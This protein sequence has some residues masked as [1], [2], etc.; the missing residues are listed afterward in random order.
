MA[1]QLRQPSPPGSLHPHHGPPG[2]H[3]QLNGH[4]PQQPKP[5]ITPQH[6]SQLNEVVWLQIGKPSS[7]LVERK[8]LVSDEFHR[9]PD[10]A[11]GRPRR[12]NRCVRASFTSQ[13]VLDTC[14]E[15]YI[16][17]TEDEGK[18]SQSCRI[19]S[20]H[21]EVRGEQRRSLGQ[22]G[23]VVK[24]AD[25]LRNVLTLC[26]G[27]CYLMMEDLQQ[28]YSAYQQALYYLRDPKV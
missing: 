17:Y 22:S 2:A 8:G 28:A 9:S 10:G 1:S 15:C 11:H 12:R 19:S 21:H 16:V 18:L 25:S 27:H 5:Q 24:P 4:I 3:P 7:V 26:E 6:M 20:G 23:Y 14:N 13:S